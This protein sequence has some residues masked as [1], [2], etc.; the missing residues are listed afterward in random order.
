MKEEKEEKKKEKRREIEM[1][2]PPRGCAHGPLSLH[3][4]TS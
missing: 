1:V 2:F 4:F 3:L